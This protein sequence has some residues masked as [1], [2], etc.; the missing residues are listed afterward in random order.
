MVRLQIHQTFGRIGLEIKHPE[1]RMK[2]ERPPLEMEIQPPILEITR[3]GYGELKI[4]QSAC[5][6]DMG[7]KPSSELSREAVE[8]AQKDWMEATTRIV[9]EGELLGHIENPVTVGGLVLDSW[10]EELDVNVKAVPSHRPNIE[11][12][13]HPAES[14]FHMGEIKVLYRPW[15]IDRDVRLG[16]VKTYM[17]QYP[18]IEIKTIGKVFDAR[19]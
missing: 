7:L 14:E 5:F 11:F 17:V 1:V 8:L 13:Y 3:N 2:S 4:D 6:S 19:V 18:S 9:Q 10:G 12:I 16:N 15:T